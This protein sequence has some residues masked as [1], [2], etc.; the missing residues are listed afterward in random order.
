M[1]PDHA[2]NVTYVATC[3]Q[4]EHGG[5]LQVM[6][7]KG[8]AYVGRDVRNGTTVIDVRDAAKPR[9]VNFLPAAPGTAATHIQAHGDLLLALN[10]AISGT[11]PQ[12]T[13]PYAMFKYPMI[14]Y[15]APRDPAVPSGLQIFDTSKPGEPRQIG[16][17]PVEGFG[18]HRLW[19][20]GGRYAYGSVHWDGF[21]DTIFAVIDLSDPTRPEFGGRWWIPG[22]HRA[23]GE[24]PTWKSGR[25]SLHHALIAGD[26]AYGAWRDGGL[27]VLDVSDKSMP[28]L[29]CH[30]NWAPPFP[31]GT[32]SPL[33]L[34]DRNLLV[35]GDETT[36]ED[37]L[38]GIQRC[39]IFDVREPANPV[40]IATMPVPA[41]QD[42]CA[43][44]GKFGMHNFHENRPG[45]LQSSTLVFCAYLN[46]GLRVWDISDAF[47][48]REAGYFVPPPPDRLVDPRQ[49]RIINTNDVYV[50]PDGL[51]YVTDANH[52]LMILQYNG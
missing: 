30:R 5:G 27:V 25:V 18:F 42:Y 11:S 19:Y 40:S 13:E 2:R 44:G 48:P 24:A 36:M 45:S 38:Q 12:I 10:R 31:G 22:M 7:N 35:V 14:D 23:A 39:W 9:M 52:G 8:F 29:I 50:M 51:M 26:L 34:P 49:K 41:E 32:H 21:T 15:A 1:K 33:P 17:L 43:K 47:Q 4:G 16:F 3:D 28:K 6:V 37:C 20:V 46:A